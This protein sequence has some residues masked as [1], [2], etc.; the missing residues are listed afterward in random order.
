MV[1]FN[2]AEIWAAAAAAEAAAA[3][4]AAAE[5]AKCDDP[6]NANYVAMGTICRERKPE[7]VKPFCLAKG[8]LKSDRTC[9]ATKIGS[10]MYEQLAG[11]FCAANKGDNW[12]RCY[13]NI[14]GVCETDPSAAGCSTTQVEHD[15]IVKDLPDNRSGTLARH[16]LDARK[17]CLGKVCA[18][19]S[20][21]YIPDQRPDCALNLDFCIQEVNVGGNL[22]GSGIEMDCSIQQDGGQQDGETSQGPTEAPEDTIKDY[23]EKKLLTYGAG[24]TTVL[25]SFLSCICILI[26]AALSVT[27][28]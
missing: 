23:E 4:A 8:R 3:Q 2:F 28:E 21:T 7:V 15:M 25:S 11:E 13:N 24:G 9:D 27:N 19:S 22:V 14:V 1:A 17:H 10:T 5:I 18:N 20:D 12:C 16:A 6:E 26:I